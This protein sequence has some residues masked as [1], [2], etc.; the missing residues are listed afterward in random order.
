MFHQELCL[1][2]GTNHKVDEEDVTLY[3]DHKVSKSLGLDEVQIYGNI[4]FASRV[5][6]SHKCI[7]IGNRCNVSIKRNW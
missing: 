7:F 4:N 6:C 5:S 3:L 2:H 1:Y